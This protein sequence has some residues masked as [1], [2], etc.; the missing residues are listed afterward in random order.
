MKKGSILCILFL[1]FGIVSFAQSKKKLRTYG[2]TKKIET[3]IKYEGGVASES[4][5]SETESYNSDGEWIER[6]DFQKSGDI[7]KREIRR[8][9]NGI[10]VE[11]LKD[12]PQEKEWIEKTPA[13]KHHVYVFE[14]DILM[15]DSELNRKG[16][17]KEKKVYEY[18][19]Y[20][21]EMAET[22]TDKN[23]ELVQTETYSYDNKGFKKEKRTVN[24]AGELIEI[25]TYSYE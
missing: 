10:L 14:K 21:D 17:V 9:E 22:T 18:N 5:I 7:K 24:A 8:Y 15:E 3:L 19:K 2:I 6:L 16:E 20:G 11:E 23:G 25:K 4:Y 13:Y 12:E 1:S